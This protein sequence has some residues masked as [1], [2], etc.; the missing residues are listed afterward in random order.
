MLEVTGLSHKYDNKQVLFD[1]DFSVRSGEVLGF[2]GPNGAG[3][4]TTMRILTGYL[5]PSAGRVVYDGRDIQ[6]DPDHLRRSLGYLPE[7]TPV[8]PELTVGEYLSWVARVKGSDSPISEVDQVM[9]RCGVAEVRRVLIR[10]LSKGFRQRL[11][12]AQAI[13]GPMRLLILDEP[14]VGLDPG[15]IREIRDFIR[16]LGREMTILLSTHILPEVELTC[17]RV[18]IITKGRIVA[19]DTPANLVQRVG[20][21]GRYLLRLDIEKGR[22]AEVVQRLDRR[23]FVTRASME[24]FDSFGCAFFVETDPSRDVRAQLSQGCTRKAGPCWSSSLP[25]SAWR[26]LSSAWS[27]RTAGPEGRWSMRS[28]LLLSRKDFIILFRSPLAYVIMFCFLLISGYF[29][30][31]AVGYY[32]LW[33]ISIM[34]SPQA[35][36]LSLHDMLIMPFLQNAG[37]ILLFFIPLLTMRGFSEEKRSGAFELLMSY[38][39]SETSLVLGKLIS[40]AGLLA[41]TLAFSMAGPA[42]LFLYPGAGGRLA[43]DPLRAVFQRRVERG[44]R[45]LLWL[46]HGALLVADR[47]ESRKPALESVAWPG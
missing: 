12:L 44:R 1:L 11:G 13:L 27:G 34:Q 15:Q 41:A 32:Q 3:K 18:L 22:E 36:V 24:C 21:G 17:D 26:R 40:L 35:G 37:V 6:R 47:A 31:S 5:T 19:E 4:S 29:F 9:D 28:S 33:S 43:A 7:T 39:V 8:Y 14:T 46:F 30:V 25:T 20:G 38:P 45:G 16:E 2:L 23:S 10:R 42:M